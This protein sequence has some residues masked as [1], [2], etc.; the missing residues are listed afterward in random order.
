MPIT[1]YMAFDGYHYYGLLRCLGETEITKCIHKSSAMFFQ[2][3]EITEVL[4]ELAKREIKA[5]MIS[6]IVDNSKY[7]SKKNSVSTDDIG[8]KL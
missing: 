3:K 5:E 1:Y 6:I 2:K 7:R 8:F 4:Q